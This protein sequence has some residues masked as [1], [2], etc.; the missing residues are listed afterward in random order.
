MK[1]KLFNYHNEF[2]AEHEV[3]NFVTGLPQIL[4]WGYR[5]FIKLGDTANYQ[6]TSVWK[7]LEEEY[8]PI[9]MR[10]G[11]PAEL[12]EKLAKIAWDTRQAHFVAEEERA[13][14]PLSWDMAQA[15]QKSA[16]RK[17]AEAVL[18]EGIKAFSAQWITRDDG[19]K[20]LRYNSAAV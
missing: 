9:D 13:V 12:T 14:E 18:D 8:V 16:Y 11:D 1:V 20:Y 6:E 3:A 7:I 19:N 5:V 17:I 15:H 4:M 2:V 10:V